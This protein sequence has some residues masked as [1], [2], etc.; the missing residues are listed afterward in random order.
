MVA[1]QIQL[2]IDG[3]G[4]DN[5]F[6][7][8][9]KSFHSTESA[10]LSVQNDIY[11]AMESG[12]VTALTLLDLSAAFDTIDHGVLLGRL[13]DWFGIGETAL[14]WIVSYLSNRSQT[15]NINGNFSIPHSLH[16]GVPQGSVLGP[17]LFILYT[18]P[19]NKLLGISNTSNFCSFI[20][21]LQ[22]CLVSVK[23]WMFQN[24]L[25]IN[26]DKT[27][28]ILIGNKS[29]RKKIDSDFPINILRNQLN[30]AS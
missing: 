14:K 30:Q 15:V 25:K 10:L 20:T 7:S 11:M 21:K 26:P 2:H 5:P 3:F 9:Y 18:T 19:L 22:N 16:F 13:L 23:D 29:H 6:Q 24:L 17:L 4:L 1:K 28:F 8:A 27:E 12:N